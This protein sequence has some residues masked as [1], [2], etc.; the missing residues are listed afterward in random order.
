MTFSEGESD[1]RGGQRSRGGRWCRVLCT[2][3]M[4]SVFILLKRRSYQRVLRSGG[5]FWVGDR[6]QGARMEA[7][8]PLRRPLQLTRLETV[9]SGPG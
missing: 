2:T 7:G 6:S 1:K 8:G 4:T 5:T 3:L 9:V